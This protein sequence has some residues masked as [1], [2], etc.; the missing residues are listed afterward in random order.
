[1][2]FEIRQLRY[3]IAAADHGSFYKA[4][5]GL[6][7]DQST[8]SRNILRLENSVGM[9]IFVRSRSG[10]RLTPAGQTF[11]RGAK[12]MVAAADNLVAMMRSAGQ[13]RAGALMLGHN[14]SVSAG[15]LR[16]TVTSWHAAQP[17]VEIEC[18]EG[19]RHT[20]LGGL[21]SGDIDLAILMGTTA[22][23]GLHRELFWSERLLIAIQRSHPL[24]DRDEVNWAELRGERFHFATADPGSELR[25]IVLGRLSGSGGTPE[26]RLHPAS[27]E[28]ILSVLGA[29]YGVSVVCEGS[30]GAQYPDV[31]Y[32]P[33]HGEQGPA[34]VGYSGYWRTDNRN[35]ALRR[36]LS[37]VRSRYALAFEIPGNL[38]E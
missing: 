18:V 5:R 22:H 16:A 31:V 1:M 28:T 26:I 3:A 12:Q 30:I 15:N 25:D 9:S 38:L 14:C 34:L 8:L 27:R 20:L 17:E 23:R 6:S 32:R 4:A 24:A 11:I 10:V 2:P 13:G 29:G 19:S 36:F 7:I 35:P 37:F 21:D 33:I